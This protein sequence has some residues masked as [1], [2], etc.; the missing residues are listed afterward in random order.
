MQIVGFLLLMV[1]SAGMDSESQIVP[2]IMAITGLVIILVS[3][4]RETVR[5]RPK[6]PHRN[7]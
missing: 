3:A 2:A 4:H 5:R 6:H 1:G 7:W